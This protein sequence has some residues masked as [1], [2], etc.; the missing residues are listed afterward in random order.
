MKSRKTNQGFT[1][2]ELLAILALI[3]MLSSLVVLKVSDTLRKSNQVYYQ[4]QEDFIALAAKDYFSDYPSRLPKNILEQGEVSVQTLKEESYLTDEILDVQK[5]PCSREKS[6][7]IVTLEEGKKYTY[8]TYLVCP[9]TQY[10]T[11][12]E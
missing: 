1:L 8:Q 7:V 12:I 2:I 6:K 3:G 9:F 11:K 10:Q 5:K 4:K